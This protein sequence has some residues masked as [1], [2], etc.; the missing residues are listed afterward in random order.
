MLKVAIPL[1]AFTEVVPLSVPV[2]V[3]IATLTDAEEVVTVL[4]PA[5]CTA[6]TNDGDK[7]I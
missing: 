7:A 6:T 5:S 1:T 2:P 3:A 4:P